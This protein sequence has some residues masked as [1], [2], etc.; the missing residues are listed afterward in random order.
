L[1]VA[2]PA[3]QHRNVIDVGIFD[4][5]GQRVLSIARRKLTLDVLI[6]EI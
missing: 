3:G 1:I 5:R 6:P 2:D 4:H